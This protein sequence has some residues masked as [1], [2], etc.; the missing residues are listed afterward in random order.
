[1]CTGFLGTC[2]DQ[3]SVFMYLH[4]TD[5]KINS[6]LLVLKCFHIFIS[7]CYAVCKKLCVYSRTLIYMMFSKRLRFAQFLQSL[8]ICIVE[9]F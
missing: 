2:L 9:K 5:A 1:M 4:I 7:I 6:L 3:L 8:V